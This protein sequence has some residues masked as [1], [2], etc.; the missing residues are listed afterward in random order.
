[1]NE[2]SNKI[3]REYL[4]NQTALTDVVGQAVEISPV[5]EKATLPFVGLSTRSGRSTPYIPGIVTPS[6]QFDCWG[7]SPIA[8][9]EVYD[10]LYSVLQGKQNQTVTVDSVD[11]LLMSAIEEVQGQ[12][13]TDGGGRDSGIQ[14]YYR[15]LTFFSIMIRAE[16]V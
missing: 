12:D 10:A 14:G 6:I 1:M 5:V 3:I 11:Y 9:R 2:D 15:V 8:A 4:V 13:I 16:A 7:A